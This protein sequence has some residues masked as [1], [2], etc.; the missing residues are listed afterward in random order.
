MATQSPVIVPGDG[1]WV[2]VFV[3]LFSGGVQ[4]V[5]NAPL[6]GLV[7]PTADGVPDDG[8]GGFSINSTAVQFGALDTETFYVRSA[9]G[10]GAVV[11][12]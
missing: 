11:L 12:A 6:V 3:G 1:S 8:I 7:V 9:G 4:N 2:E 5:G 10:E